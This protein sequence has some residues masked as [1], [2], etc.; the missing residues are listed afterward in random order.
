MAAQE[1][2]RLNAREG[3]GVSEETRQSADPSRWDANKHYQD[4]K[5]ASNYDAVRFSSL[6]GRIFNAL[7][8]RVILRAFASVPS[9]GLIVDVPCG[10]GRLAEPLLEAGYRVH[11]IDISGQMLD[12]ASRRLARFAS[13]FSIESADV[14]SIAVPRQPY[15]AALCA[16]VLMHFCFDEQVEF[17]RGVSR[18][19]N[20]IIVIN[21][22]FDSRYQRLRRLTKS[23]LGHQ[24]S[25]R[26]PVT[27]EAIRRLLTE[28]GL[29]E[30]Q[31]FRLNASISEALYLVAAHAQGA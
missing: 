6:A 10:T 7:E 8:Q 21:H 3:R 11:G 13:A 29:R 1:R 27:N 15:K 16:R 20:G 17:L 9:G 2:A 4:S 28:S 22:S 14:R 12:V 5:I 31:R 23:V 26:Y 30:I 25:A 24:K 19:T 18:L